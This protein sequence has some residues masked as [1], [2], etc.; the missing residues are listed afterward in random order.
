MKKYFIDISFYVPKNNLE[1]RLQEEFK[2][3]E[4]N[5]ISEDQLKTNL[6]SRYAKVV[7]YYNQYIG[8]AKA[9]ID[10]NSVGDKIYYKIGKSLS[11]TLILVKGEL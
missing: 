7:S 2:K 3:I 4:D 11:I 10:I 6:D 8:K 5:V 9:P 1:A